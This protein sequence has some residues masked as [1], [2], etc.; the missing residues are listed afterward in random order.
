MLLNRNIR[1][2]GAMAVNDGGGG[3]AHKNMVD[4]N[5]LK[6]AKLEESLANLTNAKN[7][8]ETAR[9]MA[10][11]AGGGES[12]AVGAAI[13]SKLTTFDETNFQVA[14]DEIKKLMA[15]AQQI[16]SDYEKAYNDLAAGIAAINIIGSN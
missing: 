4:F 1:L 3:S 14:V 10:V 16:G 2:L 12:N 13:S 6:T 5:A 7:Q 11:N 15:N 8:A 9:E